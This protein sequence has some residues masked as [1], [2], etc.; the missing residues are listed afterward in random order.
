[1]RLVAAKW[2]VTAKQ[3]NG[4]LVNARAA[5]VKLRGSYGTA[6]LK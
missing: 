1:V 5:Y 3:A 4:R 2:I 6:V